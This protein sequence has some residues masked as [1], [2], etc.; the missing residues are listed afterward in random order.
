MR[1]GT[2]TKERIER[3]ALRL[4]ADHGFAETS[5]RD[6]AREAG[7]SLGAM[8][9][10]YS[11]KDTLGWEL[12]STNFSAIGIELHRRAKSEANLEQKLRSMIGYVFELFEEDRAM[13][14]Y[15]FFARHDFIRRV[16]SGSTRMG[17]PYMVFRSTIVEAM[18]RGEIPKKDP[19]LMTSLVIGAVIQTIDTKILDHIRRGIGALSDTVAEACFQMLRA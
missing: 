16:T 17:N 3:A 2:K 10:H 1:D 5:I 19:D 8:Y 18:R 6:I 12:F 13:V 7:V 15:V 9:N 14:T 4:F 11:S